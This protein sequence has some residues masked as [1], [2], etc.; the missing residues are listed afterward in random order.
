MN[1]NL[2]PQALPLFAYDSRYF[3]P[4]QDIRMVVLTGRKARPT[5]KVLEGRVKAIFNGGLN[6]IRYREGHL[7]EKDGHIEPVLQQVKKTIMGIPYN[8]IGMAEKIHL[9]N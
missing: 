4:R 5:L 1:Y 9:S 6:F 8:K 7:V 2:H 3:E